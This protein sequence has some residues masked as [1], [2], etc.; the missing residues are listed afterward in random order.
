ME[1]L[2]KVRQWFLR[3]DHE[4]PLETDF[5]AR[6]SDGGSE[7]N[8]RNRAS[9]Q[10]EV[11]ER[12]GLTEGNSLIE[13]NGLIERS[14]ES[15]GMGIEG[16]RNREKLLGNGNDTT[17]LR[18]ERNKVDSQLSG[19]KGNG[20]KR[21]EVA[22]IGRRRNTGLQRN[23]E[24]KP[25]AAKN[26][27]GPNALL[28]WNEVKQ[29]GVNQQGSDWESESL[30]FGKRPPRWDGST[31]KAAHIAQIPVG[32]RHAAGDDNNVRDGQ[33]RALFE[34]GRV[35]GKT[36]NQERGGRSTQSRGSSALED[37]VLGERRSQADTWQAG[38]WAE[39]SR[40]RRSSDSKKARERLEKEVAEWMPDQTKVEMIECLLFDLPE[41]VESVK[42]LRSQLDKETAHV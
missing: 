13:R 19:N 7:R 30:L 11:T 3:G 14:G 15:S 5:T 18:R 31:H 12:N 35:E 37:Q 17:V 39:G 34:R 29:T 22:G 26:G 9:K 20:E 24:E 28:E 25:E 23:E 32:S 1:S 42:Q 2:E 6:A 16:E 40:A 10:K 38:R 33:T 4:G 8:G 41:M 36:G 27:T 21:T